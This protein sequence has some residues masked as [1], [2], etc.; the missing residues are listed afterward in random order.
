MATGIVVRW[1]VCL[2]VC[3]NYVSLLTWMP[4]HFVYSMD[5]L[6]TILLIVTAFYV[7]DSLSNKNKQKLRNLNLHIGL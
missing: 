2:S 7:K 3:N 6:H 4:Q 5:S 1:F